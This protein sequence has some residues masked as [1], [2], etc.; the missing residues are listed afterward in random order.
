M[1]HSISIFVL[2]AGSMLTGC[3][4][5]LGEST[6]GELGVVEFSYTA[7]FF[8]CG[9][10]KGVAPGSTA[11][12]SVSDPAD[13]E[14]LEVSST[15]AG[16]ASFDIERSCYCEQ[17]DGNEALGTSVRE[18]QSCE[19]GWTKRC[20]NTIVMEAIAEGDAKLELRTAE[21]AL[22]D[23]VVVHVRLPHFV[24]FEDTNE[25]VVPIHESRHVRVTLSDAE[26]EEVLVSDGMHWSTGDKKVAGFEE[27][28]SSLD[29]ERVAGPSVTVCA[30]GEG[31][32]ELRVRMGQAESVIPVRVV[33]AE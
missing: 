12:I 31:T 29:D 9:L 26:G 24:T 5:E 19:S 4:L 28:F 1:R 13:V 8:G 10:H 3:G 11:R 14:G 23:R 21:G 25:L 32:T 17:S 2:A 22:L 33:P 16:V 7:Y 6:D 20:N 15:N 30:I 18:D 27:L